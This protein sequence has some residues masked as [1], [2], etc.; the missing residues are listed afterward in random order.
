MLSEMQKKLERRR[1]LADGDA[2]SDVR[3]RLRHACRCQNYFVVVIVFEQDRT[4]SVVL[5][6]TEFYRTFNF[7]D[8]IHEC[9][10]T[11]SLMLVPSTC[12]VSFPSC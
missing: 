5:Y 6:C 7:T 3:R 2:V 11:I 4:G 8:V 12:H 1:R 10:V 9:S